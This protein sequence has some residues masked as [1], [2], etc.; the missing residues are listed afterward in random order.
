M[1]ILNLL[2]VLCIGQALLRFSTLPRPQLTPPQR[3]AANGRWRETWPSAVEV[4]FAFSIRKTSERRQRLTRSAQRLHAAC[5]RSEEAK[6]VAATWLLVVYAN[7]LHNQLMRNIC[8][9]EFSFELRLLIIIIIVAAAV[10]VRV[11]NNL[12]ADF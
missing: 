1:A 9:N 2:F 6:A 3:T 8:C 10:F 12:L 5:G 7:A 11:T 4:A